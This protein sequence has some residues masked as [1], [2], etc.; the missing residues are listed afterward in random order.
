[1][2]LKDFARRDDL[3]PRGATRLYHSKDY[4]VILK[5]NSGW[6]ASNDTRWDKVGVEPNGNLVQPTIGPYASAKEVLEVYVKRK[7]ALVIPK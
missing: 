2:N 3:C 7:T 6:F 5:V 4:G 1:M